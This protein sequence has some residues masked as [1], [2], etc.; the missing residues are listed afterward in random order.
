VTRVL[1][2]HGRYI[3]DTYEVVELVVAAESSEKL[4][5][6]TMLMCLV[7]MMATDSFNSHDAILRAHLFLTLAAL[8]LNHTW[9]VLCI[10]A[11]GMTLP[12][13]IDV[14]N[15]CWCVTRPD[16]GLMNDILEY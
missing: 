15:T 12:L 14:E 7:C 9:S 6:I 5:G 13:S 16:H 2:G 10:G 1:S 11:E 4:E 8:S 3:A